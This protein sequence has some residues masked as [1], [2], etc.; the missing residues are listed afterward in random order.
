MCS[1]DPFAH[2]CTASQGQDAGTCHAAV[3]PACS[4]SSPTPYLFAARPT[5][6]SPLSRKE[7]T[8]GRVELPSATGTMC[9][10]SP[11]VT[12][13]ELE[14][15]STSSWCSCCQSC[16][17]PASTPLCNCSWFPGR[18]QRLV[19]RAQVPAK[20]QSLSHCLRDLGVGRGAKHNQTC[21]MHVY[22]FRCSGHYLGRV[23]STRVQ[24]LSGGAP[25]PLVH[26]R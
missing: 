4:F 17:C 21:C 10:R 16:A 3:A 23:G 15:L 19:L 6:H 22:C 20:Q 24:T 2:A 1:A 14:C 25:A 7:T 8:E 9:T 12:C 11:L 5:K 26:E 18:C 13:R